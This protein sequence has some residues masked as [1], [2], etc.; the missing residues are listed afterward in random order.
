[1]AT[2]DGA[3]L[4][5]M[6][7]RQASLHSDADLAYRLQVAEAIQASLCVRPSRDAAASSSSSPSSSQAAAP[8]CRSGASVPHYR[9]L[10]KGMTSKEVLEPRDRDPGVAVAVLVAAVVGPL[11]DVLFMI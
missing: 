11:G 9:I 3:H 8:P 7:L 6:L 10:F 4:A 2:G 5:A 1:M